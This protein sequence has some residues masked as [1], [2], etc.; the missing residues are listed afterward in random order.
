MKSNYFNNEDVQSLEEKQKQST[1]G[2][3]KKHKSLNFEEYASEGN[4]IINEVA[5]ILRTDR[6]RAARI[7]RSVLHAIRDRIPADDAIEFAQG[8]PMALKVVFIDG[9]DISSTPV[10]IRNREKVIDFIYGKE[11]TTSQI[12]FP[13]RKSVADALHGV[14]TVLELNMDFGQVQQIKNLMNNDLVDLIEGY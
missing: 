10:R 8:L 5:Q 6:N 12:D 3:R 1:N 4:R 2:S 13:N 9:Y 11:G 14:F 7:L